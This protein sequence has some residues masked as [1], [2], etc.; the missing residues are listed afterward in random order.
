M[1]PIVKFTFIFL[2]FACA[3]V[4]TRADLVI[5]QQGITGDSTNQIITRT[6]GWKIRTDAFNN[7]VECVSLHPRTVGVAPRSPTAGVRWDSNF[8]SQIIW[9]ET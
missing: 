8:S 2:C 4:P 9:R 6:H 1:G 3:V 5:Q 7:P